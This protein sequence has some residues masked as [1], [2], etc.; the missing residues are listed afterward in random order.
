MMNSTRFASRLLNRKMRSPSPYQFSALGDYPSLNF[1]PQKLHPF[2]YWKTFCRRM[3]HPSFLKGGSGGD[4]AALRGSVVSGS[5]IVSFENE[6]FGASVSSSILCFLHLPK[7]GISVPK[8]S[9]STA[10]ETKSHVDL[11]L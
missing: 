10:T 4:Y 1:S 7:A 8:T 5:G 3:A 2:M 11:P 9:T 6:R